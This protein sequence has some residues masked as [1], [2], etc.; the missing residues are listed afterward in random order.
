[1]MA[2]FMNIFIFLKPS[3]L[4]TEIPGALECCK[5]KGRTSKLAVGWYV[6]SRLRHFSQHL[7]HALNFFAPVIRLPFPPKLCSKF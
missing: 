7:K 4:E 5:T 2:L 1:M 6:G 3:H